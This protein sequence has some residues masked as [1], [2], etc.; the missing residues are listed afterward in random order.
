MEPFLV[1]QWKGNVRDEKFSLFWQECFPLPTF[2]LPSSSPVN[3]A[4]TIAKREFA[5][6]KYFCDARDSNPALKHGK[7]EF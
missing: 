2:I 1:L 6:R 7:L 4:S 3:L 5:K